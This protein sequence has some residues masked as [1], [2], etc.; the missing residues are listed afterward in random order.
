MVNDLTR[1]SH[2]TEQTATV[3]H[4]LFEWYKQW[5]KWVRNAG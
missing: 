1:I 2:H 5:Y 4:C 3:C